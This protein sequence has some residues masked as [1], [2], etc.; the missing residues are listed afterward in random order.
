V[1]LA[2]RENILKVNGSNIRPWWIT[3]HYL[4]AFM[5]V[6]LLTWPE[7]PN[8]YK[9]LPQFNL[10]VVHHAWSRACASASSYLSACVSR[11]C[12]CQGVVQF[13]QAAYQKKRL[14]IRKAIGKV[15]PA[16][17]DC[18]ALMTC[19]TSSC[20]TPRCYVVHAQAGPM[21]VSQTETLTEMPTE[22]YA[23]LA[24]IFAVHLF[25]IYNGLSLGHAIL[26]DFNLSQPWYNFKEE[27]QVCCIAWWQSCC[28]L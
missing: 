8:Y 21:D 28:R 11:Y 3:H 17:H 4:S 6:V 20:L 26:S 1:S 27:V 7:G 14:Y 24:F 2:L 23:L 5:S 13:M 18:A 9:F 16:C 12:L 10:Y 25:Q 19:S 15:R 22:L